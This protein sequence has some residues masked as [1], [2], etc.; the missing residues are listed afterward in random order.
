MWYYGSCGV[1]GNM[2]NNNAIENY[3]GKCTEFLTKNVGL[4]EFFTR[5]AQKILSY[6]RNEWMG[7]K[8]GKVSRGDPEKVYNYLDIGLAGMMMKH[9]D[10][11][12]IKDWGLYMDEGTSAVRMF[13]CNGSAC[14]GN[15]ITDTTIGDWQRT[16]CGH[17]DRLREMTM[18]HVHNNFYHDRKN[19]EN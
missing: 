6:D 2:P 10:I 1:Q 19:L 7:Y 18:E 5:E 9:Q 3:F 15:K 11:K 17:I 16:R 14:L 4:D 8:N 13:F 12:E